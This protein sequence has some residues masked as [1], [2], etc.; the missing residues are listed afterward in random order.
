MSKLFT[1]LG[2]FRC[3]TQA[4]GL[5]LQAQTPLPVGNVSAVYDLVDRIL[6]GQR[7]NFTFT[8]ITG[9]CGDLAPPC[10]SVN[11]TG[12]HVSIYGSGTN[13]ISAGLGHYLR[14]HC[15]MVIGW[16]RG[17]GSHIVVPDLWPD[18]VFSLRRAVYWS[19]AMNVCT[20]SYSLVWYSWEDWSA[21][22]DWMALSGINNFLAETGQEEIAWKVLTEF[23][24][25]DTTIRNWFNGPALLT[26]SRG[27]NEYGGDI[28]GPLPR[29]WMKAQHALQAQIL[30]RTRS[31]GMVGQLPAFQA[32]VPVEL[33]YLLD[34]KNATDNHQGTAWLDALDPLFLDIADKWMETMLTDWGTDHWYQLDGYFNGGTAP[35]DY[36]GEGKEDAI[37]VPPGTDSTKRAQTNYWSKRGEKAWASLANTDPSAIWSYQGWA[38]L[39]A[40]HAQDMISGFVG[41]VPPGRFNV[42]DMAFDGKGEWK[43]W[44]DLGKKPFAGAHFIWTSLHTFGGMDSLRGNLSRANTIPFQALDG[45]HA[46]DDGE[47]ETGGVWGSG[48]TPEGIDQNPAFYEFL[49]ESHWRAE[50][51]DNITSHLIQRAH[52]RYQIGSTAAPE[53]HVAA[54]WALLARSSYTLDLWGMRSGGV[55]HL[56]GDNYNDWAWEAGGSGSAPCTKQHCHAD[57]TRA[58]RPTAIMC[59]VWAAWG[60][61]IAWEDQPADHEPWRYDLVNVGRE[62]LAQ[63]ATPASVRF[64]ATLWNTTTKSQQLPLDAKKITA[65]AASYTD[66]LS[67]LDELLNTD[68]AFQVGGWIEQARK[69]AA[70]QPGNDCVAKHFE[71]EIRDCAHFYEWNAKVQITTWDPTPKDAA[72]PGKDTVDYANKHWAGLIGDYYASRVAVV[73]DLALK[74][75]A[76]GV[77][78][79]AAAVDRA[80][81]KLAYEWTLSQKK[82]PT[83]P[84]GDARAVSKKMHSKYQH[85][86]AS[87]T[88]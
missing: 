52:R 13:E 39:N 28:A 41:A 47:P 66:I 29:S 42:I 15:S 25:N 10:F 86:F 35:W 72:K 33:K 20:H 45:G 8:I 78:L 6:T 84:V 1:V 40:K 51:V 63:L 37:L 64:N 4:S 46:G 18:A 7:S 24:L 44:L 82:Y 87:C 80:K 22:I 88:S 17:G 5:L 9:T 61:F 59:D 74:A 3:L 62:V 26:W 16:P 65:A 31:L 34:D 81:A 23:G 58:Y 77:A 19:Y 56:P 60:E 68:S 14:E 57:Y 85:E 36:R 55:V 48:F 11:A 12:G 73:R 53:P 75:A 27:Q 43:D 32:A 49:I 38:I 70:Q 83:V 21:F 30:Q 2:F 50:P 54:A 67:D 76:E 79:D 71:T 69:L